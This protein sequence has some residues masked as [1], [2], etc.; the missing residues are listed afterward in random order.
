MCH[1]TLLPKYRRQH[2][3][4]QISFKERNICP[5]SLPRQPMGSVFL[6][7]WVQGPFFPNSR[8]YAAKMGLERCREA[9]WRGCS[10]TAQHQAPGRAAPGVPEVA[11][12][13]RNVLAGTRS[14]EPGGMFCKSSEFVQI[15][16]RYKPSSAKSQ[17]HLPTLRSEQR[18]ASSSPVL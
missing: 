14:S 15:G 8:N 13:S 5:S 16:S 9:L 1:C 6:F 11:L 12:G 3:T 7:Q 2:K 18:A 17:P 10:S 4:V